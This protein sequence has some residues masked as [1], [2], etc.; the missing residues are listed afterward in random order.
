MIKSRAKTEHDGGI[1][2]RNA[3]TV[4]TLL[5]NASEPRYF[6]EKFANFVCKMPVVEANT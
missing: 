1:K 4:L 2:G 5:A 3:A 6:I